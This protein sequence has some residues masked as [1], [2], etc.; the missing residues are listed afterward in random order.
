MPRVENSVCAPKYESR[1]K[2]TYKQLCAGG[3]NQ[4]DSCTGDS[5][6]PLMGEYTSDSTFKTI[7]YGVVS[8]G[9]KYCGVEGFP[10][11]YTRIDKYV[12]WILD[13]INP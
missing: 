1:S 8:L 11:L 9:P 4:Q 10:T 6:G 3:V 5:G 13:N 12:G 2:L 7:Q